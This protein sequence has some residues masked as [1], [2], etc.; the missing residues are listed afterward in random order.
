MLK[1]NQILKIVMARRAAASVAATK[2]V[3]LFSTAPKVGETAAN[4]KDGEMFFQTKKH[5]P[6]F[7]VDAPDGRFAFACFTVTLSMYALLTVWS[8]SKY[9]ISNFKL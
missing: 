6:T 8:I 9:T 7:A 1:M 5:E 4:K 3:A 2:R